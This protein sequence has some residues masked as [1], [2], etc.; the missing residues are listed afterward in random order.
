MADQ[1]YQIGDVR[2]K[3][4]ALLHQ[5]RCAVKAG[6]ICLRLGMPYW[7]VKA[8]ID[9]ALAGGLVVYVLGDGYRVAEQKG[10]V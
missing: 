3:V 5:E 10:V 8:G 1:V 9:A 7:A 2:D 6:A 4:L